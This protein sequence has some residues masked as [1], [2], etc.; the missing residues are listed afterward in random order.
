MDILTEENSKLLEQVQISEFL[1][2]E[3]SDV[4]GMFNEQAIMAVEDLEMHQFMHQLR[5]YTKAH[6]HGHHHNHH[7]AL[8]SQ[9]QE[10][11]ASSRSPTDR[12]PTESTK[13]ATAVVRNYLISRFDHSGDDDSDRIVYLSADAAVALEISFADLVD[14]CHGG[15]TGNIPKS[16]LRKYL[17]NIGLAKH[18]AKA[19]LIMTQQVHSG[20]SKGVVDFNVFVEVVMHLAVEKF[21]GGGGEGSK[22]QK[23]EKELAR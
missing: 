13:I 21:E 19:D 14:R 20:S 7:S 15:P 10:G 2:K 8:P 6:G 22:Q 16:R 3:Q 18:L 4:C 23:R 17:Q 11:F 1:F 5:H 9:S 12:S